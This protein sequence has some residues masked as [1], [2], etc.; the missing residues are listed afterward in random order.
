[1]DWVFAAGPA[2]VLGIMTS[3]SPCLL[4]TNVTAISFIAR[5]IE[6]PRALLLAGGCYSLGQAL[7]FVM[8]ATLVVSSL[9]TVPVVSQGLQKYLFRLMGPILMIVG[10]FLL[11][12][13]SV[14]LHRGRFKAWAV[15][16]ASR[17]GLWSSTVLGLFLALSFCPTSAAIFFGGLIQMSVIHRSCVYLPLAFSLGVSLPVVIM[18]FLV[19]FAAHHVGRVVRG[20]NRVEWWLRKTAG[21]IAIAVGFYFTLAY[22]L[23]LW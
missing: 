13:V 6:R 14:R 3:I 22:S 17:G 11:E 7:A 19:G 15:R 12:L 4:A 18:V 10:L 21:I 2:F 1:M 23:G 9:V 8:L 20:V 16:Y 5:R